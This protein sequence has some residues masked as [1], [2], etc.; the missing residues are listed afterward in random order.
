[1]LRTKLREAPR[2]PGFSTALDGEPRP[3]ERQPPDTGRQP[4]DAID[5]Q[6]PG[7]SVSRRHPWADPRAPTSADAELRGTQVVA[8]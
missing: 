3:V 1:M 6:R 7:W 2:T 8:P 4:A 5:P